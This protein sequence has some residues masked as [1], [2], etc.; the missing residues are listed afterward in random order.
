MDRFYYDGSSVTFIDPLNKTD[1]YVLF[2][3]DLMP[4]GLLPEILPTQIT[5]AEYTVTG[6]FVVK[7]DFSNK[8]EDVVYITQ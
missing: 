5:S 2:D 7:V 6:E 4:D 3:L 8:V 1:E